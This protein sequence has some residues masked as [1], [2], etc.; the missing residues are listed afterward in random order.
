MSVVTNVI[1]SLG[2]M[3]EGPVDDPRADVAAINAYFG[4]ATGLVSLDDPDLPRGWYG[5]SKMLEQ[6]LYVGAFNYLDLDALVAHIRGLTFR[7]PEN[8]QLIVCEQDD[9]RFRII[10]V[11]AP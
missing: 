8:V 9:D 5:G 3:N 6:P 1:L 2:I 4:D 10:D 11:F 7:E